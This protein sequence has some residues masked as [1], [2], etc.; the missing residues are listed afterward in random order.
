MPR[1]TEHDRSGTMT[2]ASVL[3]VLELVCAHAVVAM[4]TT[5]ASRDSNFRI[6]WSLSVCEHGTTRTAVGLLLQ[7]GHRPPQRE[8]DV[9]GREKGDAVIGPQPMRP[10]VR[11]VAV[12]AT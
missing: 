9:N 10:R 5:S 3:L 12:R 1:S 4:P 2:S 6:I 8:S 11:P 7:D